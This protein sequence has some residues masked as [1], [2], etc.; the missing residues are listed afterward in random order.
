MSMY[1]GQINLLKEK[2]QADVAE[3]FSPPRITEEA[4]RMGLNPGFALDLQ[5]I[6]EDGEP[7]DFNLYQYRQ[8]A[9]NI[10][11]EQRPRLLVGSPECR[12]WSALQNLRTDKEALR[13]ERI[14]TAVH[15]GFCADFY[16]DQIEG[17]RR[18]LHEQPAGAQTWHFAPIR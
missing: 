16:N 11:K 6:R 7:W 15:S 9:I 3:V 4:A 14:Q 10:A 5:V 8:D 1:L 17:G 18:I 12:V 13:K 2:C